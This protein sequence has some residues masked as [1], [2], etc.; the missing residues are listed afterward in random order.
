MSRYLDTIRP[1]RVVTLNNKE[2][3]R[4]GKVVIYRMQHSLRVTHNL[5]LQVAINLAQQNG[6]PLKVVYH[7]KSQLPEHNYRHLTFLLEG[8]MEV[9]EILAA[10]GIEL[11]LLFDSFEE[12]MKRL[13]PE[14]SAVVIDKGYLRFHREQEAWLIEHLPCKLICVEDNLSIPITAA[15]YK[16][17]WAARTIRPKLMEKL[18]Y[19]INDRGADGDN[20]R[21][22]SKTLHFNCEE[23]RVLNFMEEVKQ[24]QFVPKSQFRG[25][26]R[27]AEKRCHEFI[28]TQLDHYDSNR[29]HP[30][31]IATS[32]L[33]PYLHFGMISPLTILQQLANNPLAKGFIEE[34]VVRRELAHNFVWYHPT[35]D[36]YLS[37]PDWSRRT[38][39][40]HV[41]DKRPI[42]YS[43]KELEEMKSHDACW[44]AAMYEMVT[45]GYMENTMRMYWG[46]KIVEWSSTP[47][48]A[49]Q[50][51]AYLNNKYELDGNDANSWA[52]IGWCMGLHD[53]AWKERPVFGTTR[54]MNEAGLQR[55][56]KM[57]HYIDRN[58]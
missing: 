1:E 44:N 51:M 5:A 43:L 54:Y 52:G 7:L 55:K 25:G 24:T 33:S 45:T 47:Q 27:E 23:K 4:D 10:N 11:K 19:F 6:C 30:E 38:L 16:Q 39:E 37:L 50:T 53:T 49:Y 41:T 48:E 15:S 18:P 14:M 20:I 36:Q 3:Q 22:T 56:Y 2:M 42:L 58:R 9:G 57:Q 12:D 21:F 29:N 34:L 35:Y 26:Q 13:Y 8:V 46:K 28:T 32:R 40:E 17:E 31:L